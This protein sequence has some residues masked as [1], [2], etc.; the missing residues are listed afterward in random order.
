MQ[1]VPTH[2]MS[3][4]DAA[5]ERER[6]MRRVADSYFRDLPQEAQ[7]VILA[8]ADKLMADVDKLMKAA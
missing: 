8:D 4:A 6:T 3:S 2:G 1:E 5:R 7:A